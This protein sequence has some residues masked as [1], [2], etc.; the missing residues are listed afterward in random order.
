MPILSVVVNRLTTIHFRWLATLPSLALVAVG[1]FAVTTGDSAYAGVCNNR[2]GYGYA[3][4]T[5]Y[6]GNN[7]GNYGGGTPYLY[8]YNNG[9]NYG[10]QYYPVQ[11]AG[12]CQYGYGNCG[13]SS[14]CSGGN[15]Y[16]CGYGGGYDGGNNYSYGN[17]YGYQQP[18]AN[19]AESASQAGASSAVNDSGNS[20]N[21]NNNTNNPTATATANVVVNPA[22]TVMRPPMVS[23]AGYGGRPSMQMP[24]Q[25]MLPETGTMDPI[26]RFF[27]L[28]GLV[29]ASTGYAMSRRELM[30][31]VFKRN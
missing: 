28:G 10:N 27:G 24:T 1:L 30:R 22:S 25:I 23:T 4:Y 13:V 15:N 31:S 12:Y 26:L 11:S 6:G 19:Q 18:V 21:T 5:N 29:A 7:C 9:G 17:N 16:G 8:G 20:Q 2:Y 14:G 3:N